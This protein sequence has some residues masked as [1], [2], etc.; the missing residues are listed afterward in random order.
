MLEEQVILPT[1]SIACWGE[2]LRIPN[3][4]LV[5]SQKKLEEEPIE[6]DPYPKGIKP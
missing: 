6:L 2:G 1:T 4:R 5:E 3:R